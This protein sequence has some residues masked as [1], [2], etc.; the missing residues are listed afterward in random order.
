LASPHELEPIEEILPASPEVPI[1][2]LARLL[3]DVDKLEDADPEDADPED[4]DPDDPVV[5]A[6]DDDKFATPVLLGRGGGVKDLPNSALN[7]LES[8]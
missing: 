8:S 6:D 3:N 2:L 5:A 4:A 1:N 7:E